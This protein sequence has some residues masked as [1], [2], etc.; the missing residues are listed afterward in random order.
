MQKVNDS[1]VLA[2]S[3]LTERLA[4]AH[5]T[6]QRLQIVRGERGKPAP[7]GD[8]HAELIQQRGKEHEDLQ[9]K[10]LE[11]Q[12][13]PA[14][15]LGRLGPP[16]TD[17]ELVAAS[18]STAQA[19]AVG[20]PLIYQAVLY[21]GTWQGRVDFLRR[22]DTP[23]SLGEFS[24]EVL[25][26]KLSRSV[27]PG[28]VHQLALYSR[29]LTDVQGTAPER[30]YV[31][32]GDGS[33]EQIDLQA[34]AALH[35]HTARKLEATAAA[36]MFPTYPEPVGHCDICALAAECRRRLIKDDHLSLVANARRDQRQRLIEID[37]KTVAALASAAEDTHPGQL[38]SERFSILHHQAALQIDSRDAGEPRRRSMAQATPRFHSQTRRMSSSIWK[39]IPTSRT[40]WS[41][42]GVGPSEG[43][44]NTSGL[45]T[46]SRR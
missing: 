27:K 25:D 26:A 10:V 33:V 3:D 24:Y 41:T 5:L 4:C 12:L 6:Q 13:G 36:A 20:A 18:E 15:D 28:V 17:A 14:L 22:I 16:T 34:F 21:D 37:L 46:S 19:M 31:I 11:A 8:P 43:R 23:S 38:G 29:L 35:R 7:A 1:I 39:A 30:A 9:L 32:L 42:S 45:T 40:V 44:T 2:A